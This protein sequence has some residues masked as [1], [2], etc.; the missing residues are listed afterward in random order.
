[1][2]ENN[3]VATTLHTLDNDHDTDRATFLA[4]ADQEDY[5]Q[6]A[7]NR[8]A[9]I[10]KYAVN[11]LQADWRNSELAEYLSY[12]FQKN[13]EFGFLFKNARR[14]AYDTDQESHEIL[15]TSVEGADAAKTQAAADKLATH[16]KQDLRREVKFETRPAA[17]SIFHAN[18]ATDL[19]IYSR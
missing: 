6:T 2:T 12:N 3:A 18:H 4:A 1:M 15:F 5:R 8:E 19:F 14:A 9:F 13:P 7:E 17:E 11:D 16:V 10:E